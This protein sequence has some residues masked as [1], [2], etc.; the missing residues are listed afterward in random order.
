MI[1][2]TE[3]EYELGNYEAY[4]DILIKIVKGY[5]IEVLHNYVREQIKFYSEFVV[6]ND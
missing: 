4:R 2:M 6:K 5:E 3:N 1:N